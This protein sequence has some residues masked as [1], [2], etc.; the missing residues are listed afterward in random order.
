M[1]TAAAWTAPGIVAHISALK[2]GER[3]AV[4]VYGSRCGRRCDH[5]IADPAASSPAWAYAAPMAVQRPLRFLLTMLLVGGGL[6][7]TSGGVAVAE[8]MGYD[9]WPSFKAA[10]P[11]AKMVF[12]GSVVGEPTGYG[13]VF[14]LRVDEALRGNPPVEMEFRGFK[15][16]V[17]LS[18]CNDSTLRARRTGD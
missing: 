10:V 2:A 7:V 8:C 6:T 3:I 5:D 17:P 9:P 18:I 1:R 14:R 11:S 16:G 15:S 13:S 12:V 4:A